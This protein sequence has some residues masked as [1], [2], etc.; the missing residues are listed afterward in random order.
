MSE[1][2]SRIKVLDAKNIDDALLECKKFREGLKE[3]QFQRE[4]VDAQALVVPILLLDCIED[5]MAFIRDEGVPYHKREN[6]TPRVI[7]HYERS[8]LYLCLALEH[9]NIDTKILL[10]TQLNENS[11]GYFE[12]YLVE[13][14]GCR[15]K[16]FNNHM[17]EVKKFS[18]YIRQKYNIPGVDPF[19]E[20]KKKKLKKNSKSVSWEEF[21]KVLEL[22][23][24]ENS[25]FTESGGKVRSYY[26]PWLKTAFELGLYT[27][28][29][30]EEVVQM[31]WK[32]IKLTRS[33]DLSG[34]EVTHFKLTRAHKK[35][36]AK[37]EVETKIVPMN[38]DLKELLLSLGYEKFKG[39]DRYILAPDERCTRNTMMDTIT[40][41]FNHYYRLI[42]T[43][44]DKK[45]KDL[46]K[47]YITAL[48]ILRGDEVYKDTGHEG[49]N[50][51][52]SNY[53]DDDV[54]LDAKR[55]EFKKYGKI[56]KR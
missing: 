33:G 46:R 41:T 25:I 13:V 3:T 20:M 38:E 4:Q 23:T 54:V 44:L 21:Q 12:E 9:N 34:I 18:K 45:F 11:V 14:K 50:I 30:R 55:E 6:R 5:F 10:F 49:M 28:G 8:L 15:P 53:I 19:A 36:L 2:K 40:K 16:T 42:G 1:D 29:R 32:D 35:S 51:L 43:G 7:K 22:T 17:A 48:Y 37:D 26:K 56:F 39:S 31:R 47:T 27:G 24:P 52:K